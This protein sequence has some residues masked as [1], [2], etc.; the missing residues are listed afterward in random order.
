MG[1]AL[2]SQRDT[3]VVPLRGL[4]GSGWYSAK[5]YDMTAKGREGLRYLLKG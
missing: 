5:V 4:S 3:V 2:K 1:N